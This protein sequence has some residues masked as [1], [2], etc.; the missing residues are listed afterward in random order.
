MNKTTKCAY[1]GVFVVTP[2][3]DKILVVHNEDETITIPNGDVRRGEEYKTSASRCLFEMC[4]IRISENDFVSNDPIVE[5]ENAFMVVM[6]YKKPVGDW[7]CSY[8]PWRFA[9]DS[10]EEFLE[11]PIKKAKQF[12]FS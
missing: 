6:S 4:G 10:C 2:T 7:N 1:V 5:G 9:E 3:L 11:N 12:F 8:V